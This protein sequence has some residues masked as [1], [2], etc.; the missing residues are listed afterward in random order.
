MYNIIAD[1]NEDLIRNTTLPYVD[2]TTGLVDGIASTNDIDI[3]LT[4]FEE[5]TAL[6]Q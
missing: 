6:K 3:C 5:F 1:N 4:N 2:Y